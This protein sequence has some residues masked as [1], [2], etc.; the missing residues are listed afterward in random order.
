MMLRSL[1]AKDIEYV[2]SWLA[3]DDV[4]QWL[5][6]G[7]GVPA[8]SAADVKAMCD[9]ETHLCKVFTSDTNELAIGVVGL[10][11]ISRYF[12][13]ASLWYVLGEKEFCGCGY[14]SRAVSKVLTVGF[15]QLGLR[16][17]SAWTVERNIASLRVLQRNNFRLIGRLRQAHTIDGQ[18]LDRLLFDLLTGEHH[19]PG[20]SK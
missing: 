15:S 7:N 20:L 17:V 10:S 9:D 18:V 11:N 4:R 2:A 12:R 14:A 5:D 13:S 16:S 8:V 1:T 3:E 6:F 19:D